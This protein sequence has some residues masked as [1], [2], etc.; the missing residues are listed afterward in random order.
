MRVKV[1]GEQR[2]FQTTFILFDEGVIHMRNFNFSI[3]KNFLAR[4]SLQT[5]KISL[6]YRAPAITAG[7]FY[8]KYCSLEG[9]KA[10]SG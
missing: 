4:L 9:K 5:S 3:N 8:K 2:I 6:I 7:R 1:H 10:R